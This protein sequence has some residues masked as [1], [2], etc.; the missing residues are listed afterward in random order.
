MIVSNLKKIQSMLVD[1]S[2]KLK[3]I[4]KAGWKYTKKKFVNSISW[5]EV[6]D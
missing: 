4:F 2:R 1:I 5:G 3:E 6:N